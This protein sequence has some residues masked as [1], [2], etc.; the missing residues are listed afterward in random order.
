LHV[1]NG[2]PNTTIATMLRVSVRAVELHVT[3]LL[4][5]AGVDSRAAL[6]AHV[7]LG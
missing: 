3:K 1:V 6:V 2:T 7:L 4:D 5:R